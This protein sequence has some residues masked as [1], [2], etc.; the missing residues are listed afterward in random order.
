MA[1]AMS[2]AQA[3]FANADNAHD[4]IVGN[5]ETAAAADN[6][7]VNK[8]QGPTSMSE[9]IDNVAGQFPQYNWGTL[10]LPNK[11]WIGEDKVVVEVLTSLIIYAIIGIH[12]SLLS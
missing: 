1:K 7:D 10:V 9:Q 11:T 12:S 5:T 6:E 8:N 2:L 3:M 4:S